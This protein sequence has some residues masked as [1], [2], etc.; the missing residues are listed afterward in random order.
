M[1]NKE[2]FQKFS[3]ENQ[4]RMPFSMKFSWWNEVVLTD[5]E[6]AVVANQS[7]VIAVWPYFV[8]KK[9]PWK[10]LSNPHFTPYCGP[11]INYPEG[12]KTDKR[13]SFEHKIHQQLIN[14]L[15][16]F[17][18][19]RQNLP[20]N[21][22]NSLAFIWNDFTVQNR[23]T[24]LL[25]LTQTEDSIWNNFRENIRRQIRKA[26]KTLKV[27]IHEDYSLIESTLKGSYHGQKSPYP[28][29]ESSLFER[30]AIYLKKHSTG[31]LFKAVDEENNVHSNLTLVWDNTSAYYLIGGADAA[32]KNSGA[33]SL[34]MWQAIKEAKKEGKQFFN[35]E[36][37]IIPSIEKYFRGFG[38]ELSSYSNVSKHNSTSLRIAKHLKGS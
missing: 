34:L 7:Q 5:W 11:I 17:S 28:G 21:C 9:G 20:L 12:Q 31:K 27:N 37:S 10:M 23:F 6:V 29:Y 33:L 15:P 16:H 35:F 24:Y 1:T 19:L 32:F 26:E 30:I 18:E 22:K 2:L 8:R 13:I 3:D 14:Q 4:D 36:G 25:D 38:G